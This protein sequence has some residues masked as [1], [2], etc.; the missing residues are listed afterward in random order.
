MAVNSDYLREKNYIPFFDDNITF[1]DEYTDLETSEVKEHLYIVD[2][3]DMGYKSC[4]TFIHDFFPKFDA[5]A[6]IAKM[7]K[8]KN[9]NPKYAGKQPGEIKKMWEDTGLE[10]RTLGSIMHNKIEI[11]YNHPTLWKDM[12]GEI[13]AKIYDEESVNN[14]EFQQFLFF[15]QEVVKKRWI[16]FRTECRIFDREFRIAGSVDML[17]KSPNYTENNKKLIMV[18][19]KRSKEIKKTNYF[20]KSFLPIKYIPHANYYHYS[21]QL[22]LYKEILERNSDYKIELMV[23]G[24]FHPNNEECKIYQLDDMK[25]DL[26]KMIKF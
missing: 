8:S 6:V 20:E 11:F 12:N 24:V 4:T 23:L 5:D 13:L 25:H 3:G 2:K 22:N 16:P 15:N 1:H 18:D 10:A 9:P 7:M 19:W 14:K 26:Y 17:Y 21:L